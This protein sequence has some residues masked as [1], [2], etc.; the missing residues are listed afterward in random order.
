MQLRFAE[1]ILWNTSVAISS[2]CLEELKAAFTSVS[3]NR[4]VCVM[5]KGPISSEKQRLESEHSI[6]ELF[7][8]H[9]YEI[10][11]YVRNLVGEG[12]PDS[13][14]IVQQTFAQY[15]SLG[16]DKR[17]K[18]NNPRAFLFRTASNLIADYYRSA[19]VRTGVSMGERDIET[20]A[21]ELEE[22]TPEVVLLSRQRY[23]C[24]MEAIECLPRRQ[25]RFFLLHRLK[26]WNYR[27]IAQES[28][29]GIGTVCRDVELALGACRDAINKFEREE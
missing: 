18:I 12:P 7:R 20:F 27:K 26:G 6:S 29:V 4:R 17:A 14:D 16:A 8:L 2:Q 3:A 25:R 13:D 11:A 15:A 24:V 22:I 23:Q 1:I 9:S 5:G 10:V 21:S 19:A 28:G